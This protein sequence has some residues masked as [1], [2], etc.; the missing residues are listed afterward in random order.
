MQ[1]LGNIAFP[2]LTV[3]FGS[4]LHPLILP[5]IVL[6]ELLVYVRRG[7]RAA[8]L[9]WRVLV[10]NAVTSGLGFC[11]A[12]LW[13]SSWSGWIGSGMAPRRWEWVFAWVTAWV[14]SVALEAWGLRTLD[15]RRQG[16]PD[17]LEVAMANLASYV[18][19][20]FYVQARL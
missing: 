7:G 12:F 2:L 17:F 13:P 5:F 11:L 10:V 20:A 9:W 8:R 4:G 14:A 3:A 1:I 19:L 18:P 6:V 15:W 16:H